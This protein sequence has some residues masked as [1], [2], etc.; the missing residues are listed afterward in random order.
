VDYA[1]TREQFGRAIGSFQ[2]VKHKCADLWIALEAA[3]EAADHASQVAARRDADLELLRRAASL[4]KAW[5]SEACFA[6]CAE[7]IQIHGGVGFTWEYDCHLFY[8][9]AK[10]LGVALGSADE[11]REKLIRRLGG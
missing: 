9:R 5:C 4:A 7:N 11:W 1:R 10:A 6:A 3:R 2:A 8:R